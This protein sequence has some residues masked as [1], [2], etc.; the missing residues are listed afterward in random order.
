M[1][2]PRLEQGL[3]ASERRDL[4]RLWRALSAGNPRPTRR[5]LPALVGDRGGRR[6]YREPGNRLGRTAARATLAAAGRAGR[7]RGRDHG[8]L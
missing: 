4:H 7:G 8:A 3:T 5:D 1:I 2:D 6:G